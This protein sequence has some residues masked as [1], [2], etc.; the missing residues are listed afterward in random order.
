MNYRASY[1]GVL[2]ELSDKVFI[3]EETLRQ[4]FSPVPNSKQFRMLLDKLIEGKRIEA[5]K[6]S[7]GTMEVR[8]AK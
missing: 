8:K 2:S 1:Q 4:R 6:S 7:R 3:A 5:Q